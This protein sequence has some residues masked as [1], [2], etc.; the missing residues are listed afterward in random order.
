[1]VGGVSFKFYISATPV[2][3]I[4]IVEMRLHNQHG[5]SF[6]ERDNVQKHFNGNG[7]KQAGGKVLG[8]VCVTGS[9]DEH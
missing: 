5:S 4:D 8:A 9:L 7:G 2:Y 3:P 1:M 6:C